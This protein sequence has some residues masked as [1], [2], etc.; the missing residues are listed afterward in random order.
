MA[1]ERRSIMPTIDCSHCGEEI[2][3]RPLDQS[4][5]MFDWQCPNC[6]G[7]VLIDGNATEQQRQREARE[8]ITEQIQDLA[9]ELDTPSYEPAPYSVEELKE[10][11]EDILE[12]IETEL[13][14][15]QSE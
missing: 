8:R 2:A 5:T 6:G 11:V 10:R 9:A 3:A 15:R 1:P 14:Q 12:D 7:E 13:N 4:D